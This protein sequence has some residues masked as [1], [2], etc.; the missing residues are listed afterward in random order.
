MIVETGTHKGGSALFFASICDMLNKG[1]IISVDIKDWG[2]LPKHKRILYLRGSAI[3]PEITEKIAKMIVPGE[4]VLVFLDDDH[5]TKHVL[6]E[7][8]TYGKFVTKGSYMICEDT[9]LGGNPV[10]PEY[11]TLGPWTR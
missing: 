9:M 3:S 8:R 1:R 5:T 10:K 4:K 6:Q 11:A 7:L 2:E